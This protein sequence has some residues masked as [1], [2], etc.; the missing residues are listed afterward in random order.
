MQR[1]QIVEKTDFTTKIVKEK[2]KNP[3]FNKNIV[4]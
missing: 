2:K 3:L 1:K 4:L